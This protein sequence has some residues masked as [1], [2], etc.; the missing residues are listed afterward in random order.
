LERL[1]EHPA[2]FVPDVGLLGLPRAAGE[3]EAIYDTRLVELWG[4]ALRLNF[5]P[6]WYARL[7]VDAT[8]RVHAHLLANASACR[9]PLEG[10]PL[11]RL[12]SFAWYVSKACDDRVRQPDFDARLEG[13]GLYL[14]ARK[15]AKRKGESLP[16]LT[17]TLGIPRR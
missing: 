16:R 1:L 13:E 6:P 14:E 3:A 17:F 4:T 15:R 8:G 7:E 9:F 10:Q 2:V 5:A 11:K 12:E